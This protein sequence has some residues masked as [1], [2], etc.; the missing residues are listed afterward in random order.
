MAKSK[1]SVT[2][3]AGKVDRAQSFVRAASVSELLDVA[4][5]R[6]IEDELERQHVD[7]YVRIPV[8]AELDEWAANRREPTADDDIDW[9][10]LY[11]GRP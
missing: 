1:M 4:L 3:D 7:G 8:G 11:D 6:L 10:A 2:L 5:E 9:A